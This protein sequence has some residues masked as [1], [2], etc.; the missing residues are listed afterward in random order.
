MAL[1]V[2]NP[3]KTSPGEVVVG[4]T[5]GTMTDDCVPDGVERIESGQRK[6]RPPLPRRLSPVGAIVVR[7]SVNDGCL[8][9][10]VA[11]ENERVIEHS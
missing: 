11:S 3:P 1:T 5:R 9:I 4:E 8:S 7:Q 6:A 10:A 2:T